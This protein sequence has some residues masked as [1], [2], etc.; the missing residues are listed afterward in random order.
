[1]FTSRCLDRL[2]TIRNANMICVIDKGQ[3]V[4]Q[5]S[6]S[7]L[8]DIPNGVYVNLVKTNSEA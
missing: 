3:I 7:E 6:H 4:E 2:S 5:G 1:M 8:M